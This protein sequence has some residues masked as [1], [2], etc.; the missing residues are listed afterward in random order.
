MEAR[1]LVWWRARRGRID[2]D[3]SYQRKGRRWSVSDKQYLVDSILNGFDVPKFY[4]ADFTWGNSS[5]NEKKQEYAIIDGKQRFE[6]IFDFFDDKFPLATDFKFMQAPHDQMAGLV[7]SKLKMDY[8]EV[9]EIFDNFN[10][11]VM[12]VITSQI[13]FVEEL[14]V[15]LNRSKPLSGAEI[16][17]AITGQL[18]EIVREIRSH[19][20]FKSNIRFTTTSGQD[21]NSAAKLIM[22]EVTGEL[23]ETKKSNIDRFA[24]ENA[25]R[26]DLGKSAAVV[27]STLDLMSETFQF[28]DNLLRSEGQIPVYYWLFRNTESDRVGYL[29]D[30]LEAFQEDLKNLTRRGGMVRPSE[31]LAYKTASRSVNDRQSHETRYAILTKCF[32]RWLEVQDAS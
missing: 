3:P 6:A 17:N 24:K 10:P 32:E 22:L 23:Q 11:D 31:R 13:N 27:Y 25:N 8:P 26:A 20:F 7:Y 21:L 2:V 14:F 29:R 18:T 5:L 12:S 16:R 9:S 1:T 4:L 30:F 15:R 19:D 28:K